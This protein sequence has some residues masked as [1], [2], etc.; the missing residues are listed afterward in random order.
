[1]AGHS[2]CTSQTKRRDHIAYI[3]LQD[4]LSVAGCYFS[5]LLCGYPLSLYSPQESIRQPV[6]VKTWHN[7][8]SSNKINIEYI[9]YSGTSNKRHSERR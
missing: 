2:L 9:K 8:Q 1:M 7:Y 6:K 4:C 5:Q 3:R